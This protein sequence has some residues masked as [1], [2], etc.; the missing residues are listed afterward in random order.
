MAKVTLVFE[1]VQDQVKVD[2]FSDPKFP[3]NDTALTKAQTLAVMV[4]DFLENIFN[5]NNK[6]EE[7]PCKCADENCKDETC[8]KE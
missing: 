3:E 5:Q 6:K 8:K 1:D 4:N 2:F 7:T